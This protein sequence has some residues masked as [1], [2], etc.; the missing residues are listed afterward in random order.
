MTSPAAAPR[1][2]RRAPVWPAFVVGAVAQYVGAAVAVGVFPRADPAT[3]GWLRTLFGGLAVV[4]VARPSWVFADRRRTA[5]AAVFGLVTLA[6]N[7]AF[8]Q[9]ISRVDLGVAVAVEFVG[10]VVV[11]ALGT[12]GARGS[13]AL[14]SVI[15][16]VVLVSG[17]LD[18][19]VTVGVLW[20][21]AAGGLWGGYIVLGA[22]VSSTHAGRDGRW[23]RG[24]EDLG[25]GLTAAGIAAAPV[26]LTVS[27]V[28]GASWP[29]PAV[30][31]LCVVVGVLS[32]ATPY[33]LDQIVLVRIGRARFA[34]LLALLP[35]T[36]AV[37]GAVA[38][39]QAPSVAEL[40]G[41]AA[42][43]VAIVV[44]PREV[45]AGGST[46]SRHGGVAPWSAMPS[47][48]NTPPGPL[49]HLCPKSTWL[50]AHTHGR[51]EPESLR[52][53]G[54]VHLSALSQVHVPANALFA[55]REDI[56]LLEIDP[57]RVPA[58]IRWEDGDPPH[59]DGWQFPH[60]YGPLP[61]TAITQVHVYLPDADGT[62]GPRTAF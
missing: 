61:V 50:A 9:A 40:I 7:I 39:R 31:G 22:R 26:V 27:A 2:V 18:G 51:L 20:A 60:L 56:V 34:L 23:R 30:V 48:T 58:E 29:S 57:E 3:V 37:V 11:A 42:V 62:F 55:G 4:L 53:L 44:A 19:E 54:F 14:V 25:V 49:V 35:L 47:Q 46:P 41:M 10:P 13:A 5:R 24:V 59:P 15:V 36:A 32:S 45:S 38:L 17:A 33:V 52:E 21:V 8:Y 16:G 6:M 28:T 1:W 43:V 12:R